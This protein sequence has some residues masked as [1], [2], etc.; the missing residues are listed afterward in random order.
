M[1]NFRQF[2]FK[3][4][5]LHLQQHSF[6]SEAYNFLINDDYSFNFIDNVRGEMKTTFTKLDKS[7]VIDF[8]GVK[9]DKVLRRRF[10]ALL[11][12]ILT[13]LSYLHS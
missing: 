12:A 13:S 7:S 5:F 9:A 2:R 11:L 10:T 4:N 8:L 6:I 3:A 1:R